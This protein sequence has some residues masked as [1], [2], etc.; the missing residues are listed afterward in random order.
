MI[1][2]ICIEKSQMVYWYGWVR[3]ARG[4]LM[5]ALSNSCTTMRK[6]A[7]PRHR[8]LR[9]GFVA[10]S[11]CAPVV[12]AGELGLFAKGLSNFREV[13]SGGF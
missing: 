7:Q 4:E 10:L 1:F 9:L 8:P 12:M 2:I 5:A 3:V 11:D 13:L 6:T